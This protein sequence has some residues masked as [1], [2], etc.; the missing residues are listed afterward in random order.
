MTNREQ[1]RLWLTGK[2]VHNI[3]TNECVP[4]FSCCI[5]SCEA[6]LE[7]KLTFCDAWVEERY[8]II[9]GMTAIFLSNMIVARGLD[10]QGLYI[11]GF[12]NA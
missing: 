4:D 9:S 8:D 5:P 12:G 10:Q 11:S 2:S 1:L 6:S 3:E 7:D